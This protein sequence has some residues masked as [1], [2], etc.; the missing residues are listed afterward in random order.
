MIDLSVLFP[1]QKIY[2]YSSEQLVET[3]KTLYHYQKNKSPSA[4]EMGASH[5][6]K[7]LYNIL[8]SSTIGKAAIWE[9]FPIKK[10]C[11]IYVVNHKSDDKL[12][13]LCEFL[14][15]Y[16]TKIIKSISK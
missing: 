10:A 15:V 1:K 3:C 14:V 11:D 13:C 5:L 4:F 9:E 7:M 8:H 16:D 12:N 2:C 6:E